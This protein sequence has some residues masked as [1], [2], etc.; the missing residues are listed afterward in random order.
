[1]APWLRALAALAEQEN[2]DMTWLSAFLAY[3]TSNKKH[4][5][6]MLLSIPR[7]QTLDSEQ[8]EQR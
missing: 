2:A 3:C 8:P 5:T 7:S 4:G 6:P 1:M